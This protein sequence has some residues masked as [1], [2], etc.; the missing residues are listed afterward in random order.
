MYFSNTFVFLNPNVSK[1]IQAT[2]LRCP[3][4][5]VLSRQWLNFQEH[6][7]STLF[8][9]SWGVK[10]G[11]ISAAMVLSTLPPLVLGL[12]S[13]RQLAKALTAGAVKG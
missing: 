4:P 9:T 10:W 1:N 12:L 7:G 6:R 8:I 5:A 13:Y 3:L 11:E 2:M